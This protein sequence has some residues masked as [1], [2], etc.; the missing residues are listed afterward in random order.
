MTSHSAG[1]GDPLTPDQRDALRRLVDGI[2]A[3]QLHWV[4]AYFSGFSDAR[5]V[6]IGSASPA[7]SASGETG[8]IAAA[9]APE[10]VILFGSQTGNAEKL[11]RRLQSRLS[12]RG[13]AAHLEVMNSYK[14]SRLRQDQWLLVI[15]STHGEGD[16]PDN[17]R[18]FY[19]FLHG[20]KA[21]RLDHAKFSVL[22]LGDTSYEFFC[23]TGRDLDGRLADLGAARFFPRV[24]C[25]VDFEDTA[26]GWIDGVSEV[27]TRSQGP[28]VA[29]VA[30]PPAAPL[31]VHSKKDPFHA[32]LIENLKLTGRGSTKDVR[33]IELAIDGSGLAYEPGDSLGI[34][35]SNWPE[36]V[37]ELIGALGLDATAPVLGASG[38]DTALEQALLHD[39]EITTITRP[40]LERYAALSD[41]APL[42]ELLKEESRSAFREFVYGR[43]IIDVVRD[44]PVAGITAAQFIGLLRKLP[45]RLYSIASSYRA[46]PDEIHLTIGVL[47]YESHGRIRHGVA[48][49]FLADRV[50]EDGTVPVFVD[51]NPNFRLPA[52]PAVPLIMVGP[53]TGVAP[54]RA[55]LA[56][57]EATGATGKNWLFF[58]DRNVQTDFLYQAEWLDYRARG[59]LNRIDVAFSRDSDQK[60]YV[61]HRLLARSRELYDWIENGAHVYVC[62]DAQRMAPDVHE[63]LI[64]VVE[65]EGGH[66]RE[67]AQEVVNELLAA[68]RYQRDVY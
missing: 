50:P 20:K 38:S 14:T 45:H 24:D 19:E 25:D 56:D 67:R 42:K 5:A 18:P 36:R 54:F 32:R 13:V 16:P 29:A 58:G 2:T 55:F 65:Q 59:L 6:P 34:I 3:E 46:T 9:S 23:K 11:A 10:V 33:H 22:A 48:S 28:R 49:T 57:R 64:R 7:A 15:V 60:V 41:S 35:A 51:G 61:Q 12:S 21:P 27:L 39:F 17:A 66:G 62:G 43:E 1:A 63:T 4:R 40:F 37:S 31:T 44:Y 26:Q 30:P 53:G 47:R 68:R 8:T 52:D